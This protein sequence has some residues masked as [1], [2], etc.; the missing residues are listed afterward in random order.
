MSTKVNKMNRHQKVLLPLNLILLSSA[1]CY[2]QTIGSAPPAVKGA[3]ADATVS[4]DPATGIFQYT[5]TVGN[6]SASTAGI[7]S[8]EVDITTTS[9]TLPSSDGLSSSAVGYLTNTSVVNLAVLRA[10]IIPVGIVNQPPSWDDAISARGTV[11]WSRRPPPGA[12]IA[13]GTTLSPY[14]LSSHGLPGVRRF[15][16]EAYIN[17]SLY[18]TGI[19]D[20]P[21]NQVDQ[22]MAA[23]RAARA[24]ASS[25]GYTIGPVSLPIF[26]N[27]GQL[28]DSLISL[29]HQ[30]A[31]QGW[32]VGKDFIKSLDDK[33]EDAKTALSKNRDK[34]AREK[35]RT[36]IRELEEQRKSQRHEREDAE[37]TQD[38]NH[39]SRQ[40]VNSNAFFL[41]KTNAEFIISKIPE[42]HDEDDRDRGHNGKERGDDDKGS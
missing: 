2:S 31:S 7:T 27:T 6:S 29:K 32:L 40:S 3:T 22:A 19:D 10:S 41:L 39:D 25:T 1:L 33:L 16:A 42:G 24:A 23:Q 38:R 14:V 28:I 15:A 9:G 11:R 34:Q 12:K 35:L 17:L 8:F 37:R 5:Y 26:S 21:E 13:P 36:F 20:L 4:F 30:S 18:F